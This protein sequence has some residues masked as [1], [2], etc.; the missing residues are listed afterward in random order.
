M[1]HEGL[2]KIKTADLKNEDLTA[3]DLSDK[4]IRLG[5][6]PLSDGISIDKEDNVYITD[7]EHGG[8]IRA[9][10]QGDLTTLIKTDKVRWADGLSFGGEGDWLYFTDSA[11]PAQM[12]QSKSYIKSQAPYFIYR[13]KNDIKGV[14]G[15]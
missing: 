7:V 4:V 2:Y 8:I 10:P 15:Q 14:A 11:I 6:K 13:L 5:K 1:T 3:K 9:S 12:L